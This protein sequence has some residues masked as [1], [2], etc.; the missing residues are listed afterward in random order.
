MLLDINER[1]T[2]MP[3]VQGTDKTDSDKK[4]RFDFYHRALLRKM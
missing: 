4:T 2:E 1:P 3:Q